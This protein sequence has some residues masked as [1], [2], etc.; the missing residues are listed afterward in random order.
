MKQNISNKMRMGIVFSVVILLAG[1]VLIGINNMPRNRIIRLLEL[2]DKYLEEEQYEEA[3]VAFKEV[4]EIEDKNIPAYV[5]LISVYEQTKAYDELKEVYKQALTAVQNADGEEES[6]EQMIYLDITD[7]YQ[8]DEKS[9]LELVDFQ[10]QIGDLPEEWEEWINKYIT[11]LKKERAYNE[12][13]ALAEKYKDSSINIDFKELEKEIKAQIKKE[14]ENAPVIQMLK[15]SLNRMETEDYEGLSNY[16]NTNLDKWNL[17]QE[18]NVYIPEDYSGQNGV[19][20]A[21]YSID[22]DTRYL[23][24]GNFVNGQRSGEAMSFIYSDWWSM[25]ELIAV[26]WEN[27]LPNGEY[28]Y[29]RPFYFDYVKYSVKETGTCVNG[30]LNGNISEV[31]Y[32]DDMMGN[33]SEYTYSYT[34]SD[35]I[36]EDITD[37]F[38]RLGGKRANL[39]RVGI[40]TRSG[41]GLLMLLGGELLEDE[42]CCAIGYDKN[43]NTF[44][45]PYGET[46]INIAF[47]TIHYSF[48]YGKLGILEFGY[49]I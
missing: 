18:G 38:M 2:G 13:L 27:D 41:G 20:I 9:M 1:C 23:Y 3:I 21:L 36:P 4:I 42:Y 22:E 43:E 34:V 46:D 8:E 11:E 7:S 44:K 17:W 35:G 14:E 40:G 33:I 28:E 5:G 10:I 37:E 48:K 47:A 6:Y 25:Y 39:E 24:Y 45:S 15:E 30:I 19:G 12:L 32:V 31:R 16:L 26:T 29:R 49:K